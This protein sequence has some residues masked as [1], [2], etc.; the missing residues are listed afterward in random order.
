M[1]GSLTWASLSYV[2][3][4]VGAKLLT[5]DKTLCAVFVADP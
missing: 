5:G 3:H 2:G 1:T 4:Y